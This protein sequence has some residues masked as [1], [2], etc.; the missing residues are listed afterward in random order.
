MLGNLLTDTLRNSDVITRYGGEEFCV[1][2]TNTELKLAVE[3][4]ENVRQK[5]ESMLIEIHDISFKMNL[6]IGLNANIGN[7]FDEMIALAD[8][9]LYQAKNEGRNRVVF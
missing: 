1:L 4:M 2:L 8:N 9:K 3:V 6:S 5:V 7:S